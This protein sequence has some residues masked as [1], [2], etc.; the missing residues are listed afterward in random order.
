[1]QTFDFNTNSG[2][3]T[4]GALL[5]HVELQEK[6]DGTTRFLGAANVMASQGL[7]AELC[8]CS[9]FGERSKEEEDVNTDNSGTNST[10][11]VSGGSHHRSETCDSGARQACRDKE[12]EWGKKK[13]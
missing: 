11:Q 7:R 4:T 6:C 2:S 1:M 10:G 9:C 13:A 12:E 5:A 3:A 8:L